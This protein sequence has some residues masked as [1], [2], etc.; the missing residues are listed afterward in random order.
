MKITELNSGRIIDSQKLFRNTI[1]FDQFL[2]SRIS[3]LNLILIW[4]SSFNIILWL[5]LFG[6]L[7]LKSRA[8]IYVR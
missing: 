3:F 2:N 7:V 6:A 1:I 5:C 4:T 8:T